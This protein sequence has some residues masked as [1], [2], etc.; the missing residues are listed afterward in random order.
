MGK[1]EKSVPSSAKIIAAVGSQALDETLS[2]N[3]VPH[4]EQSVNSNSMQENEKYSIDLEE[5]VSEREETEDVSEEKN[6]ADNKSIDIP[7]EAMKISNRYFKGEITKEEYQTEI[8]DL[9]AKSGEKYGVF[10][11]GE[12]AENKK[13]IP[14]KVT[15][16]EYV[17]RMVRTIIESGT[18]PEDIETDVLAEVLKNALSYKRISNK[19]AQTQADLAV[20]NQRFFFIFTTKKPS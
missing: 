1:I 2:D 5:N 11:T 19:K 12:L 4:N 15:D 14:K 16:D 6:S 17:R 10:E 3:T 8:N 13:Q 18:L 20:Q 9:L 7:T